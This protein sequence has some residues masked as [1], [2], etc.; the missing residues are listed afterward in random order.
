VGGRVA[1]E[2]EWG[3]LVMRLRLTRRVL[4]WTCMT[5]AVSFNFES[6]LTADQFV[7]IESTGQYLGDCGFSRDKFDD[8]SAQFQ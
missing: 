1:L 2:E 4:S 8:L 5:I 3:K 6:E 7:L